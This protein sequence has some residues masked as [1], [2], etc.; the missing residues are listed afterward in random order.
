MTT[1]DLPEAD[2]AAIGPV[3]SVWH[4]LAVLVILAALDV[5]SAFHLLN[6]PLRALHVSAKSLADAGMTVRELNYIISL[7]VEWLLVGIIWIGLRARGLS[8]RTLTGGAARSWSNAALDIAIAVVFLWGADIIIGML[9]FALHASPGASVKPLI[10]QG[11]IETA[12]Y[13]CVA[14]T[15]GICEETIFRGYLQRQFT[16]WSGKPVIGVIIQGVLFGAPRTAIRA[17]A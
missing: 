11:N 17:C 1:T 12:F 5:V 9:A 8:L 6:A 10:P 2:G 3:A 7:T 4:T 15:A 13:L 16:A 14:A